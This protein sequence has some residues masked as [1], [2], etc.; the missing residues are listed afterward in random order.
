[1]S[2]IWKAIPS[3]TDP[4]AWVVARDVPLVNGD[5]R[6]EHIHPIPFDNQRDAWRAADRLNRRDA[7]LPS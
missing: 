2:A 3:P 6:V 1:M 5:S 7:N 4:E